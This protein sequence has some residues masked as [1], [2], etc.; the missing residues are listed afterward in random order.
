MRDSYGGPEVLT[1]ADVEK[2]GV[3]DREVLVRVAAVSLN[4]ADWYAV[5]G[6]YIGRPQSGLRKPKTAAARRRLRRD[7]GGRRCGRDRVPSR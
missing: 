1:L 7:G 5:T 2:P 3:G 4:R 6:P